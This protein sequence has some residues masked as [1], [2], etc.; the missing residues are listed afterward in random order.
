M[1][2][3]CQ[4]GIQYGTCILYIL[5]TPRYVRSNL[6]LINKEVSSLEK[7]ECSNLR[8]VSNLLT[9][10]KIRGLTKGF[11]KDLIS[12][13]YIYSIYIYSLNKEI[14]SSFIAFFLHN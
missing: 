11:S 1:E 4:S 3:V 8:L 2:F 12:V 7:C 6:R 14:S 5:N 9:N 10:I 13:N